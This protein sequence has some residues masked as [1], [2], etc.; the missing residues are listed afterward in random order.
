[1]KEIGENAESDKK[2]IPHF[3]NLNNSEHL[4]TA[5][6]SVFRAQARWGANKLH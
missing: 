2:D 6:W 3:F 4:D 5:K 1:M